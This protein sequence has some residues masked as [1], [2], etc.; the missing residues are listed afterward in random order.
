MVVVSVLRADYISTKEHA[1]SLPCVA[2][3]IVPF[4]SSSQIIVSVSTIYEYCAYQIT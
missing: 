2:S 1:T 4:G 3:V